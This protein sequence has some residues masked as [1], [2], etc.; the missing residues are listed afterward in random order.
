[1]KQPRV[2]TRAGGSVS[3]LAWP[4]AA[5]RA[6]VDSRSRALA[7]FRSAGPR[8]HARPTSASASQGNDQAQRVVLPAARRMKPPL[9]LL[10]QFRVARRG[11]SCARPAVVVPPPLEVGPRV[12][13]LP[14]VPVVLSAGLAAPR[15]SVAAQ[16]GNALPPGR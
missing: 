7:C 5:C 16:G 13:P 11:A 3:W 15:V 4:F 1:V 12:G 6:L 8:R 2:L 9:V 10:N 14:L